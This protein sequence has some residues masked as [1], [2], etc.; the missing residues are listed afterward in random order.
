[1]TEISLQLIDHSLP[2]CQPN[3]R[4]HDCFHGNQLS[5]W[6]TS[7][8]SVLSLSVVYLTCCH[9]ILFCKAA[10]KR[11][12]YLFSKLF[13]TQEIKENTV[14]TGHIVTQKL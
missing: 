5:L 10:T 14:G 3:L 11:A 13:K 7:L 12:Y 1:M 9:R 6:L 4:S 2:C 8:L